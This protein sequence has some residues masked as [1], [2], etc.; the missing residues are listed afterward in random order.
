[1]KEIDAILDAIRARDVAAAKA[2][3]TVHVEN[4][5]ASALG[6]ADAIDDQ[7]ATTRARRKSAA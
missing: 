1:M 6:A 4:A 3:A 7:A 5:A 2:A